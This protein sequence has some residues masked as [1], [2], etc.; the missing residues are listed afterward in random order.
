MRDEPAAI[1]TT[2]SVGGKQRATGR[3]SRSLASPI[4]PST[5]LSSPDVPRVQSWPSPA[6]IDKSVPEDSRPKPG[7]TH[8]VGLIS[9]RQRM[10]P[11]HDRFP[12]YTHLGPLNGA[13]GMGCSAPAASVPCPFFPPLNSSPRPL[14]SHSAFAPEHLKTNSGLKFP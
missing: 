7:R 3:V 8:E 13:G 10:C 2:C 9:R 1:C 4:F 12:M 14:L 5:I 11:S 6:P